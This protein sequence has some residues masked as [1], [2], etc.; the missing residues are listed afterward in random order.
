MEILIVA[1][2]LFVIASQ[3]LQFVLLRRRV[4]G[5]V[6]FTP[7]QARLDAVERGVERTDRT[8]RDEMTQARENAAA[9][10][11]AFR[12]EV[13]SLIRTLAESLVKQ[14]ND[15]T[16]AEQH[17]HDELRTEMS[18]SGRE[19]RE[20]MQRSLQVMGDGLRDTI[21]AMSIAQ[22]EQ[23]EGF[24][25]E[26]NRF[27]SC[28]EIKLDQIRSAT[29]DRLQGFSDSLVRS[30][31]EFNETQR[32]QTTAITAELTKM[33]D[34][35]DERHE[36]MRKRVEERLTVIQEESGRGLQEM[37]KDA[38]AVVETTRNE[39]TSAL[40][41]FNESVIKHVSDL[42]TTQNSQLAHLA[43]A[44]DQKFEVVRTAVDER[45]KSIQQDNSE[46]LEQMRRTVD[47]Q[48]Q[49]TL[50]KRL[51]DSFQLVS[52]RLEQVYKGLG[53]MQSLATGVGDLKKVLS[54][55][56]ARG[57]W[58]E[59]QLGALLEEVLT[60]DQFDCNVATTGTSERVEF[61][62]RLPGSQP[63]QCV[64]LPLDAKFP[65]E[66]YLRLVDAMERASST[67]VELC[68]KQLEQRIRA[69]AKDIRDKYIC[70][71]RTTDFG[72]MYLPTESLY[73]EVLRR[74]GL[75]E[76]LQVEYRITVTGPT[77]LAAFLSSL[78]LGF[79][80]LAIQKRSSEV[81]ELL[82]AVKTE[83]GKY[84]EVLDKLK[85]KL[86]EAASTVEKGLTRTRVIERKL[87]GIE[88]LPAT[89]A[90]KLLP[91]TEGDDGEEMTVTVGTHSKPASLLDGRN[92]SASKN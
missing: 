83:F 24:A 42:G 20:E 21:S 37:R 86:E 12:E 54:N 67:E 65:Q 74:P 90:L 50:E 66:D 8:V 1:A 51:G 27:R 92:R 49:G 68:Y 75:V 16:A 62:I 4:N 11:R 55:V 85:K 30:I 60:R 22:K 5:V 52:E 35:A 6:D 29:E 45:L 73:A 38:V 26:L 56:R 76:S 36:A 9:Q 44:M 18:Q 13:G 28:V 72:V 53:E 82:G 33:R 7:L 3:I 25:S 40:H 47:E 61:A 14:V 70:P 63:D 64:W 58:G 88:E 71:P 41:G 34:G 17:R 19:L 31:R 43:T 2:L 91:E 81:W 79:K 10:A 46:K 23:L 77:T 89:E 57:T 32:D 48:L 69:C 39:I 78:R 84:S 59:V 87:K 80:T 15:M